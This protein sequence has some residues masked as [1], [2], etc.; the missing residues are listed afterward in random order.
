MNI[1]N[2]SI[3]A[4]VRISSLRE[5][6]ALVGK[7][8]TGDQPKTFWEDSH[9][10]LRFESLEEALDTL[11]D[12]Y[13]QRCFPDGVRLDNELSEVFEF[14]AYSSDMTLAW[15]VVERLTGVD[16][17]MVVRREKGKWV[18]SYGDGPSARARSAPVAICLAALQARGIDVD[19]VPERARPSRIGA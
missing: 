15:E 17:P 13:F 8:L 2:D 9:S 16:H 7:Y 10:Y 3:A 5:L 14:R 11:G 18:A 6:D 19:F 12:P 4:Q 1:R